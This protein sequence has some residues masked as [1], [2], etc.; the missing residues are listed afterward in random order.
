MALKNYKLLFFIFYFFLAC[1]KNEIEKTGPNDCNTI[2]IPNELTGKWKLK[3]W[4]MQIYGEIS[5]DNLGNEQYDAE[6]NNINIVLDVR[7]NGVIRCYKNDTLLRTLFLT[8]I[9]EEFSPSYKAFNI[10]CG[11]MQISFAKYLVDF[12]QIQL[13]DSIK[14]WNPVFDVN[15]VNGPLKAITSLGYYEKIE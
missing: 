7:S 12:N 4:N 14:I 11:E 15:Y 6:F 5:C 13:G 8:K 2:T 9:E 10:E 1:D 3:M